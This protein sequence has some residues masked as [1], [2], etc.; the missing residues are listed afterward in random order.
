MG[1]CVPVSTQRWME[2]DCS[3]PAAGGKQ[4]VNSVLSQQLQGE[5]GQELAYDLTTRAR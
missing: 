3:I 4:W 1:S 2:T 5:G